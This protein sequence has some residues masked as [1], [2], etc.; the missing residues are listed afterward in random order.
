LDPNWMQSAF[1]NAHTVNEIKV[2][3]SRSDG[4]YLKIGIYFNYI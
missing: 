4:L 3:Q 1:V 2:V